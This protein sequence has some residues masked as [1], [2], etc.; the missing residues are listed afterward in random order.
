MITS[1]RTEEIIKE[2]CR[3][4]WQWPCITVGGVD[5]KVPEPDTEIIEVPRQALWTL[6]LLSHMYRQELNKL[7]SQMVQV[8]DEVGEAKEKYEKLL[9]MISD[10][11]SMLEMYMTVSRSGKEGLKWTGECEMFFMR[12]FSEEEYKEAYTKEGHE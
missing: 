5:G 12:N 2:A 9:Q 8:T 11:I 3:A 7:G 6:V 10:D 1:K 4:E